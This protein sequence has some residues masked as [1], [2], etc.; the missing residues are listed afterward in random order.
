ME[1]PAMG[2]DRG[3]LTAAPLYHFHDVLQSKRIDTLHLFYRSGPDGRDDAEVYETKFGPRNDE[4]DEEEIS[5]W[6]PT[7]STIWKQDNAHST[8]LRYHHGRNGCSTQGFWKSR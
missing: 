5:S 6:L 1:V 2:G 3:F 4:E 7:S 8:S